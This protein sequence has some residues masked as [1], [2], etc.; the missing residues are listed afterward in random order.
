MKVLFV[1]HDAGLYGASRS[2][3]PVVKGFAGEVADLIVSRRF[4]DNVS[5]A[6]LRARFGDHLRR[7]YRYFLP[8]DRI[9]RGKD[10]RKARSA[11]SAT[12]RAML[13]RAQRPAVMR[14]L[15]TEQYDM[16]HLN[17]LSLFGLVDPAYPFFIHVREI[18][19][20][21][22]PMVCTRLRQARGVIFIDEATKQPFQ[23]LS[24]PNSVVLNNPCD[25]TPVES[26]GMNHGRAYRDKVVF[27]I[28][29]K[30]SDNKGTQ[31]VI[32][33]F[34]RFTNENVMLF[35]VGNGDKGYVDSCKRSAEGDA[36]IR[37][38]GEQPEIEKIYAIVDYV[39]RGEAYPCVGRT[40]YEGLYA[41]CEVIVPGGAEAESCFF[42]TGR[43]SGK[44]HFYEPRNT[45][46]LMS[47]LKRH[48]GRKILVRHP[49]SNVPEYLKLF[50]AFVSAKSPGQSIPTPTVAVRP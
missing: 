45:E 30:L 44:L 13:W 29:G 11:V 15:E 20:G 37:F 50:K 27:A 6:D 18:Y 8:F 19:D 47:Q 21:T 14:L 5:A 31:F 35:I 48:A 4:V 36:R 49:L 10:T 16:I 39:L 3:Q 12:A 7:I 40:I 25:M 23:H 1:T 26:C 32:E 38:L 43:F 33:T 22:N 28:I 46:S 24:L 2:L 42:E 17:S 9:Y 34:R 41:G